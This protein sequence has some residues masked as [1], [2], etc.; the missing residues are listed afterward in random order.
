MNR[1]LFIGKGEIYDQGGKNQIFQ[2][3]FNLVMMRYGI[4][5]LLNEDGGQLVIG[6]DPDSKIIYGISI[7]RR[8][9]DK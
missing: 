1:K 8:T 2:K 4:T 6:V 7:D 3:A 9:I 5:A